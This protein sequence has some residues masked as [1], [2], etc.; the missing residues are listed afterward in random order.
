M[1]TQI[2][3]A[4]EGWWNWMWPMFW[5]VS[6]LVALSLW[7]IIRFRKLRKYHA[8]KSSMADLPQW[9]GPLLAETAKKLGLRKLPEIALSRNIS[10]PA[11]FGVFRPVLVLPAATIHR[12]SQERTEHILLHELAHIKRGDLLVNT[13]YMLLQIVYWF[14]PLLWLIRRRLQH[15]REL[16]CDATVARILRD[17]TVDY[18]ETILE[19]SQ[20]YLAKPVGPGIG[21]LGMT[22]TSS[23]LLVR[24]KW[25][26]KRTWK[27][28]GIRIA[29][30]FVVVA[31]MSICVLPMAKAKNAGVLTVAADGSAKYSSIQ[32]AIDAADA[33]AVIRIG[34]GIYKERLK[35]GSSG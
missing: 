29:T 7:V 2:N 34:P 25:L 12:L 14:N 13:F 24:L 30:I 15:L 27:Y 4:A 18:R 26:E 22:E 17:K 10:S 35:I 28:R 19:V 3:S 5:Q 9:F 16:C 1:I 20:R 31:L 33:G 11:V 6:V 8:G 23:R 21:L 32:K